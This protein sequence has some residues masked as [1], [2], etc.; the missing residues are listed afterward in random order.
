MFR[1]RGDQPVRAALLFLR[2]LKMM[3]RQHARVMESVASTPW[4]VLPSLS[5]DKALHRQ[6]TPQTSSGAD[7]EN[8]RLNGPNTSVFS[9]EYAERRCS[10]ENNEQSSV[11]LKEC[12]VAG[13]KSRP[14]QYSVPQNM[15][16]RTAQS[17]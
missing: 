16:L 2:T 7:I 14:G 5:K 15:T 10:T 9:G 4:G 12:E 1:N 6:A 13:R 17:K 3:N 8:S 11:S